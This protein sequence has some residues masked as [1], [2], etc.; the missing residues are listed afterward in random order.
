MYG[1]FTF[2]TFVSCW[3]SVSIVKIKIT[4]ATGSK[5]GEEEKTIYVNL[6]ELNDG[7]D[8]SPAVMV[9]DKKQKTKLGKNTG[10]TKTQLGFRHDQY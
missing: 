4:Y 6:A 9:V 10:H 5:K 8:E 1:T 3:N 7:F 2:I